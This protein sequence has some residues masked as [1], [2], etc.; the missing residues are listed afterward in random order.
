[1]CWMTFIIKYP[2]VKLRNFLINFGLL[3]LPWILVF[4]EPDLGNAIIYSVTWLTA[5]ILSG[6]PFI[7]IA[8]GALLSLIVLPLSYGL[9]QHYQKL[10]LLI[11]LNPG[12]DPTGAGY[13]AIQ[14][15]IA[16]GSGSWFGRGFGRGTQSLLKFLP[17]YHTDFIFASF[18][19][20]F[21]LIG[22]LLLIGLYF[23]LLWQILSMARKAVLHQKA[24]IFAISIFMLIFSQ[25]VVNIG[26]N[27]GLMP[28]TGITLPFVSLGGSSLIS[29][30]ICMGMLISAFNQ[31][32]GR[33]EAI[34]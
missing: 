16:V 27:L 2:P 5:I 29:F 15:M 17:E 23:F 7:Y 28:I 31:R 34:L 33:I 25:M 10:R 6:L 8:G 30:W 32:T 14:A 3:L 21:G 13:N 9:L 20:E 19:E 4:R 11:F 18:S 26:M 22:G 1:V 24:F 12:L